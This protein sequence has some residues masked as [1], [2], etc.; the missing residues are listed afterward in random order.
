MIRKGTEKIKD[1]LFVLTF[2]FVILFVIFIII[3]TFFVNPVSFDINLDSRVFS[4]GDNITLTS[5]VRNL[6]F[7]RVNDVLIESYVVELDEDGSIFNGSR[8]KR[9][10]MYL[11]DIGGLSSK[12]V[13]YDFDTKDLDS[14]YY[15]VF[16]H[17]NYRGNIKILS[18]RF[19]VR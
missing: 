4:R 19:E 2:L 12:I 3:N 13:D 8:E 18:K 9:N 15:R 6:G 17:F 16:A 7:F 14:G 10:L 11:D 5:T 1:L